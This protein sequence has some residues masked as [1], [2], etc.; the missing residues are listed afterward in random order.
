[1]T[2][3]LASA[4]DNK[5]LG[6]LRGGAVAL[7]GHEPYL[8]ATLAWLAV[9]DTELGHHFLLKKGSVAQL[10]GDPEP[11]GMQLVALWPPATLRGLAG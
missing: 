5:L 7:V 3:L 11:G 9:G 2:Q 6:H 10:V 1:V 8:S 4:P